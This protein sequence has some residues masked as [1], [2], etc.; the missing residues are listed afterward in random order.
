M[1]S[2]V[3]RCVLPQLSQEKRQELLVQAHL[4]SLAELFEAIVDPRGRHGLRYDLPFLLACLV[5]ATLS[6][7]DSSEAVS[8]WCAD[9]QD[10]LRASFG[11]RM[12]LTPSGSLY[13]WL[14]PQ[15]DAQ[16]FEQVIGTWVQATLQAPADE[17]LA[18]DGKTVRGVR[19]EEQ[20]APHL[21]S[22]CMHQS[23]ETLLQVR[24]SEKTNEIPVAHK[25]LATLPIAHRVCTADALHTQT[26]F[27]RVIHELG[28]DTVLT[29]KDNQPTLRSD[30][31]TYF[32]DPHAHVQTATT[33]DR[34]R[35]R[36]E[37]RTIRVSTEMNDYLAST[38]PSIRQVAHLTRTVTCKGQ[39]TSENVYLI[40]STLSSLI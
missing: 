28:A 25:L 38:W 35:G 40:T 22:F 34:H 31:L 27:M 9:H 14:L 37:V 6:Q 19:T 8:Q 21:L 1:Y 3:Q 2:I 36:V 11:P 39:T 5:A 29:V 7:C 17:P 10:L 13:R 15:L 32:A 30:L 23:Q 4:V 20:A 33:T 26:E 18:L 24:V 16:A 12:F